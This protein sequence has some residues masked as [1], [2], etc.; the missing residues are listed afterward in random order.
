MDGT[1]LV[2]TAYGY[3]G[4]AHR[5]QEQADAER[6]AAILA[7]L[8][9]DDDLEVELFFDGAVRAMPGGPANFSVRF[10]RELSADELILDRVRARAW[11]RGGAVT[12]VTADGAL[13][14]L[15]RSEG[16]RWLRVAHGTPPESVADR[17]GGRAAR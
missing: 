17:I 1:N 2:R 4:P 7:R 5:A 10:T 9:A 6:L 12:V 14:R 15:T 13:G 16:G 11:G 8:C 3:G